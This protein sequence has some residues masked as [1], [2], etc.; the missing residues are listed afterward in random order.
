MALLKIRKAVEVCFT[1]NKMLYF[2]LFDNWS[3][4]IKGRT[5][6]GTSY[7]ILIYWRIS[8]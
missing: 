6:I 3:E 4:F 8:L 5:G 2:I 1:T 7:Y